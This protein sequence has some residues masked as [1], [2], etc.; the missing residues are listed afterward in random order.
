MLVWA[1]IH[2]SYFAGFIVAAAVALDAVNAAKWDR[3]V[4]GRWLLFG[5]VSVAATLL[6]A[7][8]LAGFLHP[9][10]ISSM[11]TLQGIGEWHPSTTRNTPFFFATLIGVLGALLVRGARFRA[12][13]LCLLLLTL[14]MAFTHVRHQSIFIILAALIVTP[15]LSG[16]EPSAPLFNSLRERRA[17]AVG[18]LAVA[19]SL[20]GARAS[21][22][23][24]PRETFSNPRGLIA[25]VPAEL[26]SQPLLN[27]YSLG[28][29]LILAGIRPFI[30]GRA[31]MYGDEFFKSYMKM[32]E[33]DWPTFD[34]AVRKYQIRWTMLQL[35]NRLLPK[36]DAS[37]E[38]RRLYSDEVGVIHVRRS[39]DGKKAPACG[40]RAERQDCR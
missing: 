38:W 35:D 26:R 8:G 5:V 11:E 33:G 4:V 14:L 22:P 2:G 27:E 23:L 16:R 17:W 39:G 29:P 28:G 3:S 18:S 25:H 19:L 10:S 34:R 31:D 9:V 6:N 12:G 13:E 24:E 36:L 37:P 20:L 1:N 30:D 15:K 32:A 7:N 40:E 21:I